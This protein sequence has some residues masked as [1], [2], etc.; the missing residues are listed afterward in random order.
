MEIKFAFGN[1]FFSI[2]V[3]KK[4]IEQLKDLYKALFEIGKIQRKNDKSYENSIN[5]LNM[6]NEAIG[7]SRLEG[8]AATML[9][10]ITKFNF[11]W[12]TDMKEQFSN[13]DF[14]EVFEKYIN[15]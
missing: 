7:K 5:S 6:A 9:E 2:D 12:M 1:D 8:N 13:K 10:E 11:G 3:D 4:Q 14:G 15:N